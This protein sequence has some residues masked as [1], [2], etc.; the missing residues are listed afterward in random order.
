MIDKN[1]GSRADAKLE[2]V[3]G[4][5]KKTVGRVIGNDRMEVEGK[6]QEISGKVHG[7]AA[8]AADRVEEAAKD[9]RATAEA[10]VDL[11]KDVLTPKNPTPASGRVKGH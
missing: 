7:A 2:E 4:A 5:V 11:A 1:H 10:G 9:L 6:A 8:R 3:G